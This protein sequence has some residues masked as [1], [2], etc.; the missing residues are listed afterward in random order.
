M[1]NHPTTRHLVLAGILLSGCLQ[2]AA[3]PPGAEPKSPAAKPKLAPRPVPGL[4]RNSA[5]APIQAKAAPVRKLTPAAASTATAAD[6]GPEQAH[7]VMIYRRGSAAHPATT[8]LPSA[9]R[10]PEEIVQPVGVTSV[11]HP[12]EVRIITKEEAEKFVTKTEH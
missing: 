9:P 3:A 5:P 7:I 2:L 1:K 12:G 4:S 11:P 10:P 6:S 8:P